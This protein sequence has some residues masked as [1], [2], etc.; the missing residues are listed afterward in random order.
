MVARLN[1]ITYLNRFFTAVIFIVVGSLTAYCYGSL[2]IDGNVGGMVQREFALFDVY[3][4][5]ADVALGNEIH[6][7]V[8]WAAQPSA[9]RWQRAVSMQRAFDAALVTL[10]TRAPKSDRSTIDRLSALH[11]NAVSAAMRVMLLLRA[12]QGTAAKQL[13]DRAVLPA[14]ETLSSGIEQACKLHFARATL[15]DGNWARLERLLKIEMI[16]VGLACMALLTGLAFTMRSFRARLDEATQREIARLEQA[17]LTDSLT[18][19]GNHRAFREDLLKEIARATRHCHPLTL[20]LFDIDDFKTLNDAQG[21]AHGDAVLVTMAQV[22]RMTRREDRAYRIGGDEFA[23]LFV[24]TDHHRAAATIERLRGPLRKRLA[25]STV[26]IGL[27]ELQDGFNEHDLFERADAA[28]YAA[29]R[30]GRDKT[31]DF[32][33][34]RDN[35]VIVPVRKSIALQQLLEESALHVE[36][37][38]I[39]NLRTREILGFEALARPAPHLGLGGPAEA[40]DIAE[41]QRRVADLDRLCVDRAFEAAAGLA[42]RHRLF[43]NVTPETLGRSDF[44]AHRLAATAQRYGIAPQQLVIELT[45]RRVTDTQEMLRHIAELRELGMLIALDDTGSGFAGLE[46]LSKF[47]FD[48]VKIDRSVIVEAMVHRRACG[49]LAG[50]IAIAQRAGSFVI[51]EGVETPS[52]LAFLQRLSV[53]GDGP[54]GIQGYLLGRPAR[55]F[56]STAEFNALR[57]ILARPFGDEANAE[58]EAS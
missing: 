13:Y 18:S 43:I 7:N 42:Q 8:A 31:V 5:L 53:E 22:L 20:V 14:Y 2:V 21:H 33:T 34:I 6:A 23:M 24:E 48:F 30:N 27:C 38:P 17:A 58:S 50:I 37:Q 36:F 11:R 10:R 40:F 1:T 56:P 12:H 51:A 46:I 39:W 3:R 9:A 25:H 47:S 15:L 44:Q 52:Q 35:T 54:S 57:A 41:R 16:C 55:S 28:L 26:S 49:V 4:D 32:A 45:E 29:K 19:L